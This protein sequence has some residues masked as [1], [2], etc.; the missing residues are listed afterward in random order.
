MKKRKTN[1]VRQ[2]DSNWSDALVTEG[3]ERVV[4]YRTAMTVYE[5]SLTKGGFVGRDWNGAGY[6]SFYD[7]RISPDGHPTPQAFWLELDGQLLASD[8]TWVGFE[9]T[10]DNS[11]QSCEADGFTLTRQGLPIRLEGALTSELLICRAV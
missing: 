10:A 8:W 6:V 7:G 9:K 5:E 4:S 3:D 11:G 2:V 1:G